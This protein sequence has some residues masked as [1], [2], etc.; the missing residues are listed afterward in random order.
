MADKHK[1]SAARQLS[2][3]LLA[4]FKNAIFTYRHL[5]LTP[6]VA[7]GVTPFEFYQDFWL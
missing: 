7:L 6:P 2:Q 1:F 4:L 5:R 3:R